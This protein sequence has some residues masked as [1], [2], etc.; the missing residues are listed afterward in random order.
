[1]SLPFILTVALLFVYVFLLAFGWL[2]LADAL[3]GSGVATE[4]ADV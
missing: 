4:L 3:T 1:M 2:R